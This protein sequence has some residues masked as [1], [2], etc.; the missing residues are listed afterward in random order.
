MSGSA[1]E[2]G[3]RRA[4][5]TFRQQASRQHSRAA[6]EPSTQSGGMRA[7]NSGAAGEP[8]TVGVQASPQQW[9]CRRALNSGAAGES[10]TVE[11]QA[12]PQQ[13]GCRRA[14]NSGVAGDPSTVLRQASPQQWGGRR[15]L[16]NTGEYR[17]GSWQVPSKAHNQQ[18]L[19]RQRFTP[20]EHSRTANGDSFSSC[21]GSD[22]ALILIQLIASQSYPRERFWT[23]SSNCDDGAN[24]T[25][26]SCR[27]AIRAKL[28]WNDPEFVPL[29]RYWRDAEGPMSTSEGRRPLL[30]H[31]RGRP[32][33]SDNLG[34]ATQTSQQTY[35]NLSHFL[36]IIY[37]THKFRLKKISYKWSAKCM[38][39]CI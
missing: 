32:A 17:A 37:M 28:T 13:W 22:P 29:S 27:S 6:G 21:S 12:S 36:T 10:S 20:T 7:L 23:K 25:K 33:S 11:R 34:S 9:G 4:L 18:C 14:L 1:W 19:S 16:N 35:N 24:Q 3:R 31:D 2:L 26:R 30:Q 39:I 8:S 5:N 38:K 15:A